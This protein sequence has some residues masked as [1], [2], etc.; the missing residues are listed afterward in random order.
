MGSDTRPILE[1]GVGG[2]KR[3]SRRGRISGNLGLLGALVL[4]ALV[5]AGSPAY[6]Q[7]PLNPYDGG[8]QLTLARFTGLELLPYRDLWTLYGPGPPLL[9]SMVT[10]LFGR[11]VLVLRLAYVLLHAALVLSAYFVARLFV[12]WWQA[13]LLVLPVASFAFLQNHFHFAMSLALIL[14]GLWL[15]LRVPPQASVPI[16]SYVGASL[17]GLSFLGRY[18]FVA[19]SLVAIG[20]TTWWL[21]PRLGRR[22]TGMLIAGLMPPTLFLAYLLVVV[23]WERAF[24]NLIEFPVRFYPRDYCRGLPPIWGPALEA[25]LAPLRGRFWIGADLTLGFGTY[26]PPIVAGLTVVEGIRRWRS[27]GVQGLALT[28]L[29]SLT[30][31]TWLELRA[32]AGGE[33][34]PVWIPMVVAAAGLSHAM[35]GFGRRAGQI[36]VVLLGSLFVVVAASSWFPTV[37]PAWWRWPQNHPVYGFAD[38]DRTFLYDERVWSDVT[39]V[40]HRFAQDDEPIFVALHENTGHFANVPLLYWIL[41]RPPGSRFIEFNPCL[42]DTTQVQHLI[43]SDLR[44]TD[45][46]VTT[47]YF[48]SPPPPVGSPALT[49]DSYLRTHFQVV[50]R[51]DLVSEDDIRV[52]I[53]TGA[54]AGGAGR[55]GLAMLAGRG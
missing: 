45:V 25:L 9:G 35:K 7:A 22:T 48:P 16:S 17:M 54:Q 19:F 53:R 55:G 37:L 1:G 49:L 46:V 30:L 51:G 10:G 11:D 3:I 36:V 24:L 12:S 27:G 33:P 6:L 44:K 28:I 31:F 21:R 39:M 52:L 38:L 32:R 40:V 41:D 26:A 8:V 2:E 23:G 5:V 43:V 18:E 47:A 34:H 13:V 29:G 20:L 4:V 50:Y 15:I 14:W 42:T